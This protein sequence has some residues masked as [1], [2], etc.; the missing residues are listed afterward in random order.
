M[1]RDVQLSVFHPATGEWDDTRLADLIG[2]APSGLIVYPHE[3]NEFRALTLVRPG[4]S[5]RVIVPD[6]KLLRMLALSASGEWLVTAHSATE[7]GP[8]ELAVKNVESGEVV[9]TLTTDGS[10]TLWGIALSPEGERLAVGY[11]DG[12]IEVWELR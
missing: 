12:L 1:T 10:R 9:K 2:I 5:S 11:Y 8:A 6:S 3:D 4:G 7:S